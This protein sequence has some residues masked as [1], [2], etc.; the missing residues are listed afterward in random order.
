VRRHVVAAAK[1][2]AGMSGSVLHRAG[3]RRAAP[4]FGIL[5][6]HRVT[7]VVP[8]LP[9]PTWNVTPRRFRRQLEGLLAAGYLV[10]PLRRLIEH[11]ECGGAIPEKV[12]AI[13]FDD[14]YQNTYLEAWPILDQLSVPATVFVASAYM[15]SR[16][17]FPFD[18]WGTAWHANAP[19]GSWRPLEWGEC[20]AMETSGLVEIGT[21]THTHGDFRELAPVLHAEL[22]RSRRE[23]DD[24][25]GPRQPLFAFPYGAP[26]VGFATPDQLQAARAAGVRCALTTAGAMVRRGSSPFGWGR[27]EVTAADTAATLDAKLAGYYDWVSGAK[28]WFVRWSPP[29]YLGS[30]A[31]VGRRAL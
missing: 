7:P 5:L 8:G 3:G 22:E 18:D 15:G 21:H 6:Y 14:G 27:F 1:R 10:W 19:A 13:T 9:A 31:A 11:A 2:F 30:R 23:L 17:P 16:S 4:G 26:E 12:T 25:L 28:R 20:R 24:H 29:P